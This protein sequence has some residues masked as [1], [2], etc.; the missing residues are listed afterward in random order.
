M[1]S[2]EAGRGMKNDAMESRHSLQSGHQ[3]IPSIVVLHSPRGQDRVLGVEILVL[4]SLCLR[5]QR[6]SIPGWYIDS[7]RHLTLVALVF[8][9]LCSLVERQ[10]VVLD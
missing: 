8:C 7:G 6:M 9:V 2:V 5:S 4:D 1:I 10:S 3:N